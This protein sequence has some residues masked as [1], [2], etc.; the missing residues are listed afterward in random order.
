VRTLAGRLAGTERRLDELEIAATAVRTSFLVSLQNLQ[1]S[2]DPLEQAAARAFALLGVLDGPELS[3]P[4]V[5]RLLDASHVRAEAALERLVDAQLLVPA[6]S[7]GRYRLHDLL[8]LYAR[9]LARQQHGEQ[10]RAAALTRV[11]GFYT[12]TAWRTLELLRPGDYQLERAGDRWRKGG[13]EFAGEQEALEWLEA[14]RSNLLAAVR[15]AADTPGVPGQAALQLAQALFGFFWVRNHWDDWVEVNQT[16]LRVARRM[17]DLAGQAKALN[18][19]AGG[20]L[21]QGCYEQAEACLQESLVTRREL[22]DRRGESACLANL[23]VVH[24]WQGRY[25]Q[26]LACQQQSLAIERELGERRGQA[27]SLGN[28]AT[29]CLR[30]GRLEEALACQQQSLA[31]ERELGDRRGQAISLAN[32][33]RVYL[34]LGRQE[35]ALAR[36]REGLAIGRELGDRDGEAN[37]LNDLGVVYRLQGLCGQSQASLRESL[38]I[39]RELADSSGQAESLRELG[40]TMLASGRPQEARAHWREAL[41]IYEQ[42]RAPDAGQVRDLLKR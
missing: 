11:L 34:R 24:E 41:A 13:L 26:A 12:A 16:A 39:R 27:E 6:L 4:V 23:G 5:A 38:T 2:G 32:L 14:E 35:E 1:A 8:R 40:E 29:V 37:C 9:E 20:Y 15:Q 3:T 17:G 42:L 30:L 36:L 7:P 22:G 19:I 18:D 10:E 28:V 21:R 25:E 33:G 31:I